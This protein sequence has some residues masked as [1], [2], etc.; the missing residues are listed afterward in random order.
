LDKVIFYGEL[1]VDDFPWKQSEAGEHPKIGINAGAE[2]VLGKN[3][4]L[5]EYST[6]SKWSYGH[7][8]PWQRYTYMGYGIGNSYGPDFDE[9]FIGVNHHFSKKLDILLDASFLRKGEG[10][11][12]ESY[13]DEFP[14]EYWITGDVRNV[15]KIQAG[16]QVHKVVTLSCK[17]GCAIVDDAVHPVFSVFLHNT[18]KIGL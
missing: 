14:E 8:T 1:M 2:W 7:L 16:L 6:V 17:A 15:Y 3:Y 9:I 12:G 4:F 13:P 10:T 5:A 18:S 11:I